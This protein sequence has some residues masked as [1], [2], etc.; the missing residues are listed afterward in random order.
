MSRE[1]RDYG[2]LSQSPAAD[3][4]W[5]E[6]D[7]DHDREQDR[8]V[9]KRQREAL[10]PPDRPDDAN[11]ECVDETSDAQDRGPIRPEKTRWTSVANV[12]NQREYRHRVSGITILGATKRPN[13]PA[14]ISAPY[15][16][17]TTSR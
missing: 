17:S 14:R 3:R 10:R 16:T 1:E 11:G 15:T 6:Y 8:R 2:K 4:D 9:G 7:A 5:D 13:A 12:A